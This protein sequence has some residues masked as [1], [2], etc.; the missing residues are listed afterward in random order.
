MADQHGAT[1][2]SDPRGAECKGFKGLCL[3][4]SVTPSY[5]HLLFRD[6]QQAQLTADLVLRHIAA[7][8]LALSTT[9]TLHCSLLLICSG[10]RRKKDNFQTVLI[11]C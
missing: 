5:C 2:Q 9:H 8:T 11:A 7:V 3:A 4:K 10:P 6:L 1:L